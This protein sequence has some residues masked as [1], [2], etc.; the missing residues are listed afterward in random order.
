MLRGCCN[1]LKIILHSVYFDFTSLH[2]VVTRGISDE[3]PDLK[4]R[5]CCA[6]RLHHIYG[7]SCILAPRI[8]VVLRLCLE[9]AAHKHPQDV[10][11]PSCSQLRGTDKGDRGTG[12][13]SVSAEGAWRR[14][15]GVTSP[16]RGTG[17]RSFS[18][19]FHRVQVSK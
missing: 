13:D 15:T 8:A 7:P 3:H 9:L 1:R 2:M 11:S 6:Y 16:L 4:T 5:D 10:L 18:A 12:G 14:G 17:E 19:Q